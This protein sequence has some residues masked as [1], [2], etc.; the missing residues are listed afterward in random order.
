MVRIDGSVQRIQHGGVAGVPVSFDGACRG[1][2][3]GS[4]DHSAGLDAG[5]YPNT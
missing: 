3:G 5:G 2:G 1:A 4:D